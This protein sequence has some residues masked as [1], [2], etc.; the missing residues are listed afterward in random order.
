MYQY[1]YFAN[2]QFL[3][4]T[5]K[6]SYFA[7]HKILQKMRYVYKPNIEEEYINI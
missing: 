5:N 1:E 7:D 2:R 4:L 3:T 6:I